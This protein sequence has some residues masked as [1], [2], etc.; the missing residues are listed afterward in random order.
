VN[1]TAGPKPLHH[2]GELVISSDPERKNA[3]LELGPSEALILR[4]T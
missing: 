4:L 3:S 1:F 2:R